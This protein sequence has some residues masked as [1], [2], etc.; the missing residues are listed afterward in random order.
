MTSPDRKK[1]PKAPPKKHLPGISAKRL[2]ELIEEATVDAYGDSE[3]ATAL[4]S[5]I[6][7]NMVFPFVTSVLG[8]KVTVEKVDLTS[9]DRIVAICRRGKEQQRIPLSDLPLPDPP[10][11][12]WEWIEA[13]REWASGR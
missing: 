1:E 7:D 11:E 6:E 13:Y 10:P 8:I 9:D 4:F 5:V 12:G 3:Q 2:E